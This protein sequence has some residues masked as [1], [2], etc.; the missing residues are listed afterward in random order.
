MRLPL[1]TRLVGRGYW[2]FEREDPV[3]DYFD[4][5]W[6]DAGVGLGEGECVRSMIIRAELGGSVLDWAFSCVNVR[7]VFLFGKVCFFFSLTK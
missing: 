3:G 1:I 4:Y 6:W 7:H 5:L 2:N